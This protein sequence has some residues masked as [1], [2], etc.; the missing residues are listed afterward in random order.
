MII[1]QIIDQFVELECGQLEA[2]LSSSR[3][4]FNYAQAYGMVY[5]DI[6]NIYGFKK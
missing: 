4:G 3:A 1:N 6:N 2:S 5:N